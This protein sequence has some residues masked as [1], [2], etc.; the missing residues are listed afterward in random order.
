VGYLRSRT[1]AVLIGICLDPPAGGLERFDVADVTRLGC[2]CDAE[3]NAWK[4]LMNHPA[5]R[6]EDVERV[7]LVRADAGSHRIRLT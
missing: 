4:E 7:G 5:Y 6:T 1:V 3:L 2:T